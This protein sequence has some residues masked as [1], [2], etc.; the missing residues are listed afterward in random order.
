MEQQARPKARRRTR[1][2]W[3]AIFA[4]QSASG[5]TQRAFCQSRGL[6]LNSFTNAKTRLGAEGNGMSPPASFVPVTLESEPEKPSAV[7][8]ARAPDGND[9][10]A[11]D[12]ELELGAGMVLRLRSPHRPG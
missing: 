4:E 1:A 12:L 8:F 11:W 3:E 6:S 9:G 5:L 7:R 2:Q 10:G